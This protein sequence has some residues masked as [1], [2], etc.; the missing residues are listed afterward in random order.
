MTNLHTN[1]LTTLAE[2]LYALVYNLASQRPEENKMLYI[3]GSPFV[4]NI[5]ITVSDQRLDGGKVWE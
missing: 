5:S 1:N 3:Q 4:I 2:E